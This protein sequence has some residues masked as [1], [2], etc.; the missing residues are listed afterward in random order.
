MALEP[1]T[2]AS[3]SNRSLVFTAFALTVV[4]VSAV[5]LLAPML[6]E[7]ARSY[8]VSACD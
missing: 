3:A 7:L 2:T 8:G 5:S 6:P 4:G 1:R